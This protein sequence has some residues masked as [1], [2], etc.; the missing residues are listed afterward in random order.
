MI[1]RELVEGAVDPDADLLVLERPTRV[2]TEDFGQQ[3]IL[4]AVLEAGLVELDGLDPA[5][6][7]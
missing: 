1:F 2:A 7:A 5:V 4:P 3:P 6:L